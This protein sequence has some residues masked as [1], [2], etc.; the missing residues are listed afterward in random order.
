VSAI[1]EW[2]I[3]GWIHLLIGMGLGY[4]IK[5]YG[6]DGIRNWLKKEEQIIESKFPS[7]NPPKT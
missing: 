4:A 1:K 6:I 5:A 2:I 3:A 7:K